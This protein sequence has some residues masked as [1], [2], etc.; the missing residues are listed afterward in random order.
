[1]RD[2][3]DGTS[4][5][6]LLGEVIVRAPV[7]ATTT[8]GEAGSYWRGGSWN[9]YCFT[10]LEGPNT[11][12]PDRIYGHAGSNSLCKDVTNPRA[13]CMGMGSALGGITHNFARSYHAGG[14]QVTL[15]DASVRF[16]SDNINL[17]IWHALATKAGNEVI[18][19]Y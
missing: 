3:V 6:L 17:P 1:M 7:S 2:I 15:A 5:T 11:R 16:V 14:V 12:T 19:E 4:N 13:P 18:G 10:T 9:E 8:F